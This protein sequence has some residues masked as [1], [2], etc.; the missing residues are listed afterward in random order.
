MSIPFVDQSSNILEYNLF[1]HRIDTSQFTV[2]ESRKLTLAGLELEIGIIGESHFLCIE[3]FFSE[4][5]ACVDPKE[6]AFFSE[7]IN[8]DRVSFVNDF[9]GLEISTLVFKYSLED[10]SED[11]DF[12]LNFFKQ[13]SILSYTF[14]RCPDTEYPFDPITALSIEEDNNE[15]TIM[16][17]HAYP[18]EGKIVYSATQ[19]TQLEK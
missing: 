15:I 18:N 9:H 12:I 3:D 5:L 16:T 7:E 14:P 17:L 19:I 8:E 11:I 4:V 6:T 13:K 10:S 1:D 2:L